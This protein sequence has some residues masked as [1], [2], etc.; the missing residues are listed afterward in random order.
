MRSAV[1]TTSRL[2]KVVRNRRKAMTS[3]TQTRWQIKGDYFE[4]C[5]CDV[6]CPCEVAPEGP[7]K[8][9]PSQGHCD[10]I[11]A[12]HVDEGSYGDVRLDGLSA[13][14]TAYAEG[15]MGNGNWKLAMYLDDRAGDAQREALQTI[16]SGSVG[17]P[18]AAFAPLVGEVLGV[19]SVPIRYEIDGKRRSVSIPGIAEARVRAVDSMHPDGSEVWI[20]VGHPFNPER[21]AVAVGEQG[22]TYTDHGFTWDN[23]GRAGHYAPIE[24]SGL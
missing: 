16:L 15:P 19:K 5:S 6:Q 2:S 9:L 8:A 18:M 3:S 7:L 4:N 13:L 22:S 23:S 1:L 12:L 17:G 20:S 24:W 21:L 11:V 14:F 10:A